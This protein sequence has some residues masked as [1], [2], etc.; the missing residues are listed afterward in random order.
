[1]REVAS[2]IFD[3]KTHPHRCFV[4]SGAFY[5]GRLIA[6]EF[7]KSKSHT[8]NSWNLRE[9]ENG[10]FIKAGTCSETSLFVHLRNKTNI[11]FSKIEIVNVRI[12]REDK[13]VNS[14]PCSACSKLFTHFPFKSLHYTDD[15]GEF[16]LYEATKN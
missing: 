8:L 11:P 5:K 9:N 1:M 7:N 12:N 3:K 6:V 15:L 2:A 14:K 13:F 16:R 4:C 10:S